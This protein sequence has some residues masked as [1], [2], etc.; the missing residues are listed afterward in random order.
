MLHLEEILAMQE[1]ERVVSVL[2]RSLFMVAPTLFLA[3][4]FLATPFFFLFPLLRMGFIGTVLLCVC[5]AVGAYLGLKGVLLWDAN[6]LVLTDRR[7][8][9][10]RQHGLWSRRVIEAPLAGSQV[11][12][13]RSGW[14]GTFRIGELTLTGQGLTVPIIVSGMPSAETVARNIQ[15]LRDAQS[16]GFKVRTV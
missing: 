10:V 7:F 9:V 13:K 1:G 12:V 3:A 2:R 6:V 14:S 16:A 8:L 11:T 15:G 5:I 4:L